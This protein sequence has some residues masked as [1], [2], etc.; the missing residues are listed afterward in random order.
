MTYPDI[1]H[2]SYKNQKWVEFYG[3]VK[4][5]IPTNMPKPWDKDV[6][7]IMYV[8]IDHAGD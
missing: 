3:N 5:E 6:D 1:D 7:L 8:D 4:E 2:G